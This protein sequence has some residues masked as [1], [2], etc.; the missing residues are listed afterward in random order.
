MKYIVSIG[1]WGA[2]CHAGEISDDIW[3]Y[4]QEECNSDSNEYA[5]KLD[6]GEVPDEFKLAEDLGSFY[7]AG[8]FFDKWGAYADTDIQIYDENNNEVL[9]CC[10][11]DLKQEISNETTEPANCKHCFVWQ[12]CE[13]SEW[14]NVEITTD[15]PFN[16]DKLKVNVDRLNLYNEDYTLSFVSSI[17]YDGQIFEAECPE[18]SRGISYELEF[19]DDGLPE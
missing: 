10:L 2:E 3:K 4:I 17:E 8:S 18:E 14:M 19:I 9:N 5:E 12:S 6:S 13:K 16:K 11:T 15:E 1:R 7:D